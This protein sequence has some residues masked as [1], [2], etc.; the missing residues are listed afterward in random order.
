VVQTNAWNAAERP[1]EIPLGQFRPQQSMSLV[2]RLDRV[3][4]AD[5]QTRSP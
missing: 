3:K 4:R 5:G 1:M 2:A